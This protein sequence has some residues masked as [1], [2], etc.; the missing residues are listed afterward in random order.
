MKFAVIKTGGKQY[1]VTEGQIL[2]VE[3]LSELTKKQTVI[4]DQVLLVSEGEKTEIG[5]PYVAGVKVTA[6]HLV[7]GRARKL[8]VLKY[9]PKT[10]YRVKRGHRQPFSSVKI[11]KLGF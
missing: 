3:K 1:R 7:T 5:R 9:K 6:E 8:L 11:T 2:K 10:R 4:F